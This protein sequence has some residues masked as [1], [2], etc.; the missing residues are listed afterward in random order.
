MQD[1]NSSQSALERLRKKAEQPS[2]DMGGGTSAFGGSSS[3]ALDRLRQKAEAKAPQQDDSAFV[4]GFKR[5]IDETQGLLY[6]GGAALADAAGAE[7]VRDWA[8]EG[9]QRNMQEAEEHPREVASIQEI[10]GAG[11]LMT[12][13]GETSGG[14]APTVA[15]IL[16]TGGAG[17][18]LG[19]AAKIGG[20]RIAQRV[21][22]KSLK[23]YL[24][25]GFSKEVAKQM[26]EREAS[27]RIGG[28]AGAWAGSSAL[29]TG[30]MYGTEV[31]KHGADEANPYS[32][33]ALG[34]ASGATDLIGGEGMLV[35]R[36]L[37]SAGKDAL[38]QALKT[39]NKAMI[40]R[41]GQEVVKGAARE[42]GQET[43]QELIGTVNERI[44]DPNVRFLTPEKLWEYANAG[45]AGG[46]GGVGFGAAG[47][48]GKQRQASQA[49]Q[50]REEMGRESEESL[51]ALNEA[52]T[53]ANEE[54]LDLRRRT[55]QQE[56]GTPFAGPDRFMDE[57]TRQVEESPN[58]RQ[59]Q[60]RGLAPWQTDREFGERDFELEA[61][62]NEELQR[63]R[64]LR[65]D[66]E[67]DRLYRPRSVR[68]ENE[69]ASQQ[70]AQAKE[71]AREDT[72]DVGERRA[73]RGVLLGEEQQSQTQGQQPNIITQPNEGQSAA[74]QRVLSLKDLQE[75]PSQQDQTILDPQGKPTSTINFQPKEPSREEQVSQ[76]NAELEQTRQ[77][78]QSQGQETSE[79]I[80][81]SLEKA[82][83]DLP[84]G[85][86]SGKKR[87][88]PKKEVVT[89]QQQE[90][91][92]SK[93]VEKGAAQKSQPEYTKNKLKLKK[94]SE[95]RDIA[96]NMGVDTSG[97]K[98]E[99][100]DKIIEKQKQPQPKV[101]PKKKTA[102]PQK[103][104][105]AQKT[106]KKE[107]PAPQKKAPVK[108]EQKTVPEVDPQKQPQVP[109]E[110]QP[111]KPQNPDHSLVGRYV[112]SG[113]RQGQVVDVDKSGRNAILDSGQTVKIGQ[114]KDWA[115]NDAPFTAEQYLGETQQ[116]PKGK[117]AKGQTQKT[118]APE[119]GP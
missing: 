23:N 79:N 42:G 98:L 33:T 93:G 115:V 37:G 69:E 4:R 81:Q 88:T 74:P 90:K 67:V 108:Q 50:A 1:L 58:E 78:R 20:K 114:G 3:S 103:K 43:L 64:D 62:V 27:K 13:L 10:D 57:Q 106:V 51:R 25:R 35:K 94:L 105:P 107:E 61:M 47:F 110:K 8:L 18:V 68:G 66:Q 113:K 16:G 53:R 36:F 11:D 59:Q 48:V 86:T 32:S 22:A 46:V 30:G 54:Q 87:K 111:K 24:D 102:G 75:K 97:T 21:A 38:D 82:T 6:A 49:R 100:A 60:P 89:K 44:N 104:K 65:L 29:E 73:P 56:Q 45:A 41:L 84:R 118:P 34:V 14:L 15:T 112:R 28:M 116:K 26:A 5:N 117:K 95:V 109:Q 70:L 12:W 99:L 96:S 101:A 92:E 9:Y 40:R 52:E 85:Q 2:S 77:R 31:D 80:A 39:G 63:I 72:G 7:G 91:G 119:S 83:P 55:E 71:R 76:I 17:A 19:G